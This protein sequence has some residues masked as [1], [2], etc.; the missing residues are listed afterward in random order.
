MKDPLEEPKTDEEPSY[1]S[2]NN[3]EER[4]SFDAMSIDTID[5]DDFL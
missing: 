1:L 4:M 2:I 5:P 3:D